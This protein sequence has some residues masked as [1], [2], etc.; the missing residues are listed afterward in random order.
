MLSQRSIQEI[1]KHEVTKPLSLSRGLNY[2][3]DFD[4]INCIGFNNGFLLTTKN[5]LKLMTGLISAGCQCSECSRLST[6][7]LFHLQSFIN[8]MSALV[9]EAGCTYLG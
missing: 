7:V 2:R 1:L 5:S 4:F 3:S 6:L 9:V 8:V